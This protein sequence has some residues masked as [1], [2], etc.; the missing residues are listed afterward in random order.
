MQKARISG[1]IF[2]FFP[3]RSYKDRSGYSC[4]V[5]HSSDSEVL[6]RQNADA[7][8]NKYL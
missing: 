4:G 8:S 2:S 1:I 5:F 6:E 3:D 7:Y